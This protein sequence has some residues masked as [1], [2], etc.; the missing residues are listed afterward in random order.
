[1]LIYLKYFSYLPVKKWQILFS[2]FLGRFYY[3]EYWQLTCIENNGYCSFMRWIPV[4]IFHF[5]GLGQ[6]FTYLYQKAEL[7]SFLLCIINSTFILTFSPMFPSV[8]NNLQLFVWIVCPGC[9][10]ENMRL[11]SSK[12]KAERNNFQGY[13]TFLPLTLKNTIAHTPWVANRG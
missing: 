9:W 6:I 10:H 7:P 8:S 5:E 3:Q 1:M 2:F 4:W 12:V 13:F 11:N